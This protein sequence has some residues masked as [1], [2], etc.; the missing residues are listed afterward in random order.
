[1]GGGQLADSS[2]VRDSSS[3]KKRCMC[4]NWKIVDMLL[5]GVLGDGERTSYP[6]CVMSLRK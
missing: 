4:V 1:M 6:Q 2:A 5:V 3:L